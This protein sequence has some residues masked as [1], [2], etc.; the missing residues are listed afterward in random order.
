MTGG[1]Q[2]FILVVTLQYFG[3]TAG[4]YYSEAECEAAKKR[5]EIVLKNRKPVP[6]VFCLPGAVMDR[7]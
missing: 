5:T 2:T 3:L 4:P 1:V 7:Q 6:E